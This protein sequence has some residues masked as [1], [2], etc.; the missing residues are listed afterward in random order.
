MAI[1]YL[2]GLQR[3][4][5]ACS[6][7]TVLRVLKSLQLDGYL[8]SPSQETGY[9]RITLNGSQ[10]AAATAAKPIS[11]KTAERLLKELL[12]RVEEINQS[13]EYP[14]SVSC[15]AVFGSYL[16]TANVLSDLDIGYCLKPKS[17]GPAEHE[18][19]CR[20]QIGAEQIRAR[21]LRSMAEEVC[22]PTIKVKRALKGRARSVSLQP[23]DSLIQQL[24]PDFT[25]KILYGELPPSV[26]KPTW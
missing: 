26:L 20:R 10:L 18:R 4:S 13:S 21:E 8:E 16:K 11:R 5:W 3:T 9:W 19:L 25:Y 6:Q 7:E 2:F 17:E 22:W 1:S 15:V 12:G 24:P 14:F 23:L